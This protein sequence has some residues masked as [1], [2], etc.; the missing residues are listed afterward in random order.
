MKLRNKKT[1]EICEAEAREDGIYIKANWSDREEWFLYDLGTLASGWDYYV[2]PA[3][4]KRY[5]LLKDLPTFKAG[6]EFYTDRYGSL[7][8]DQSNSEKSYTNGLMAYHF[9]TIKKFPSILTDWFEEIKPSEPLIN[10]E[11]I[12]K[13]VRAWA[14]ACEVEKCNYNGD[15][16]FATKWYGITLDC[17]G[18]NLE[19]GNYTIAELCGDEE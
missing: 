6:D 4:P 1:G 8:Y 14:E 18:E 15:G 10:D 2:K 9:S 16:D 11:K 13:A 7:Y 12:R 17:T 19:E 5:R 3:E